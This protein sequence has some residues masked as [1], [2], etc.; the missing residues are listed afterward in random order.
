MWKGIII[1][2]LVSTLGMQYISAQVE[3]PQSTSTH[4]DLYVSTI[5][6]GTGHGTVH[7][8]N[9]SV[10]SGRKSLG[11]GVI[12]S[13]HE[14]QLPGCDLNFRVYLGG[15][16]KATDTERFYRPYLKYSILYQK[17]TSYAPEILSV[18]GVEYEIPSEPGTI[19]TIGHY[20]HYG[21]TF[22]LTKEFFIESSIGLGF[23]HGALDP[24]NGPGTLGFHFANTGITY[25]AMIGLG[26]RLD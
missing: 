9:A 15:L 18:H 4:L 10:R 3:E 20:L 22:R 23:Y 25:S 17:G 21:S 26:Y 5:N 14:D 12:Y 19:A 6:A 7:A 13:P 11:L 24:V 1:L 2:T 16:L 8:L